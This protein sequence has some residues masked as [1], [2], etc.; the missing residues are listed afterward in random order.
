MVRKV[1]LCG[2]SSHSKWLPEN[3]AAKITIKYKLPSK[4]KEN[5]MTLFNMH[6]INRLAVI[7]TLLFC[8]NMA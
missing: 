7:F 8:N 4:I 5:I 6:V 2:F 3:A 1:L